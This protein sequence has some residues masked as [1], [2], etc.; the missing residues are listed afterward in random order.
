MLDGLKS[1][2]NNFAV[3]DTQGILV[4]EVK[5]LTLAS[6]GHVN[7]IVSRLDTAT[8]PRLFF[9]SSNLIEKME[10][11]TESIFINLTA[12]EIE[13]LPEY[14]MP[15]TVEMANADSLPTAAT[16]Q[17]TDRAIAPSPD[18]DNQELPDIHPTPQS[19]SQPD[20]IAR[21]SIR[22]LEE[23]LVVDRSKHKVGEVIV[24]KEIETRMVEV[25]VRREILI[26]EQAGAEGKQLAEIDLGK[27]EITGLDLSEIASLNA[28]PS[29]SAEFDSPQTAAKFLE[30][31]AAQPDRGCTKVRVLLVLENPL[32]QEN[33]QQWVDGYFSSQP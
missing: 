20:D 28:Q 15:Q 5:D 29:V 12:A 33:Y 32:V 10:Y 4:G 26:I 14:V 27:G 9:A 16:Y 1:Q 24:R 6:D 19:I 3:R 21:E 23:R 30:A 7:L 8:G 2:L 22:L 25:P 31:I 13:R 11:G 17:P 18:I